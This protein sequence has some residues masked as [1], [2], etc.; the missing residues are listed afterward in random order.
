M[1]LSA[2]QRRNYLIT[3]TPGSGMPIVPVNCDS[4]SGVR[5]V[6]FPRRYTVPQ[7]KKKYKKETKDCVEDV[8]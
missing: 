1:Q 5:F 3:C 6:A 7:V 8:F 2:L 4:N